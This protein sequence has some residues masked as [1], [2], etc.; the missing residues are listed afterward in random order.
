MLFTY[1]SFTGTLNPV[2]I[3]HVVVHPSLSVLREAG[4]A[5]FHKEYERKGTLYN[6]RHILLK[7]LPKYM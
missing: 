7:K 6:F 3:L 1:F 5:F 4:K 2:K